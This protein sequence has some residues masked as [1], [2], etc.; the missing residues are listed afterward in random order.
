LNSSEI[1]IV[2]RAAEIVKDAQSSGPADGNRKAVRDL[3]EALA[4]VGVVAGGIVLLRAIGISYYR[5]PI[6]IVSA[7][8]LATWFMR[9]RGESWTQMG[10]ALPRRWR[11]TIRHVCLAIVLIYL[12]VGLF[13]GLLLPLLD[14]PPPDLSGEASFRGDP[15]AVILR[16]VVVA[17]G[18]AAFAEEMV[19]RGFVMARLA[20]AFGDDRRGRLI[21]AV[22]QSILFGLGHSSQG[23]T[24]MLLTGLI[25]LIMAYIFYR[26]G[27]SLWPCILAH[28]AVDTFGLLLI[29]FGFL[30][31]P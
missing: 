12:L 17:W 15:V 13:Q 1:W 25:G 29:Y 22:A 9:I 26:A 24:G 20:A 5:G 11:S 28:G 14:L 19:A 3:L 21:A 30:G 6:A 23:G 7:L 31:G 27:R 18:T 8:L 4:V 16:L 10:M 2:N